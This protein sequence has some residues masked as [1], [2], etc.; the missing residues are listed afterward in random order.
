MLRLVG[1]RLARR[2]EP[3]AAVRALGRRARGRE[4]VTAGRALDLAA[5]VEV[6]AAQ[7]ALRRLARPGL[8]EEVRPLR[9]QRQ[10]RPPRPPPPGRRGSRAGAASAGAGPPG[11]APSPA[12]APSP[13]GPPSSPS[14]MR[15]R[16]GRGASAPPPPRRRSRTSRPGRSGCCTWGMRPRP[17]A[18]PGAPD[19][20]PLRRSHGYTP[21][22]H[23]H[24]RKTGGG[25]GP[26]RGRRAGEGAHPAR[27]SSPASPWSAWATTRPPPS[28]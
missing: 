25:E 20:R 24:R 2:P 3:E 28:T 1:S 9:V 19:V 16:T 18:P 26:G 17:C 13:R 8:A 14:R 22:P 11:P 15:S 12:R 5:G 27:V 7:A 4:S 6:D 10:R 23:D 21:P